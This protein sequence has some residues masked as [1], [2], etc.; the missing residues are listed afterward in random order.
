[1]DTILVNA[2]V[3][4][5]LIIRFDGVI[6]SYFINTYLKLSVIITV[7][8]LTVYYLFGMYRSLWKYASIDELMQLCFAATTETILCYIAGILLNLRLPRSV[9]IISWLLTLLFI[10][11]SR[12]SYRILRRIRNQYFSDNGE[13]RKIMIIGAGEAGSMIIKELKDR[14]ASVYVPVVVVDDDKM[15]MRSSI[16]GVPVKGGREKIIELV[17]EYG[18]EE[19][20]IALPSASKSDIADILAI[21]KDTR[22]RLKKLPGMYEIIDGK[23]TIESLRDVNIEDLMDREE[24]HLDNLEISGYLRGEI[25]L[26]TGGGGSIGSELC[27]QIAKFSPS[28]II[29]FDIYENNAYELQNV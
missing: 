9:F 26:V 21:C 3:Y 24:V 23:L 28:R 25:V 18:V 2:A 6:P 29:I 14:R 4:I 7:L 17:E 5:G 27:R 12:L 8:K 22:C 15:K 11:G 1:M 13:L 19:I 16:H 20:M 10:G